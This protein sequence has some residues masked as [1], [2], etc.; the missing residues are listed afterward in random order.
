MGAAENNVDTCMA[1]NGLA[2]ATRSSRH[3]RMKPI[4]WIPGDATS[5]LDVGCN[6][7]NECRLYYPKM[8]LAG[9]DTNHFSIE[10]ANRQLLDAEIQQ[11]TPLHLG[12]SNGKA[13][14]SA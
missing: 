4:H 6:I 3:R 8:R 7:L 10:K 12:T 9:I 2:S 13:K 5:L 11:G 1:T 14:A